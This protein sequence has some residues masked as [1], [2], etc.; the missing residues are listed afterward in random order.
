[1][2][3]P[4]AGYG[5]ALAPYYD[6]MYD[7]SGRDGEDAAAYVSGLLPAGAGRV[8]ELGVG[9]GRIAV[10]LAAA[11]AEVTGVD[12][13][14]RMLE[15]LARRDPGGS[16]RRVEADM[17]T[18]ADPD[19]YDVVLIACNT[20]FMLLDPD[21]QLRC[22]AGARDNLAAGGRLVVEVYS[23]LPWVRGPEER[24]Q[25]RHLEP[26][27]V[28]VDTVRCDPHAQLLL[29]VHVVLGAGAPLT[30][31]ELSRFAW[32]AELDRMAALAG[33]S[34]AA[35]HAG[36][37][38]EAFDGNSARHVSTYSATVAPALS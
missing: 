23:P 19:P 34:L 36:W 5:E 11:G 30:V 1:V 26:D 31:P 15:L 22:L 2:T 3:T 7:P 32:P 28:M 37:R 8:L 9:T 18:Y 25:V 6:R 17:L 4:A 10:P 24:V 27:T 21:D 16:V 29:E 14:P 13:S 33:L 38:G 35:R 20:L 12:A